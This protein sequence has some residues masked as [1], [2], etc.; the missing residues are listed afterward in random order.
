M[1]FFAVAA[2][3]PGRASRSACEA[4]LMSTLS[5]AP[6]ASAGDGEIARPQARTAA[7]TSVYRVVFRIFHLLARGPFRE[8]PREPSLRFPVILSHGR[9]GRRELPVRRRA[10]GCRPCTASRRGERSPCTAGTPLSRAWP[11]LASG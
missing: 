2:P 11:R 8:S 3:T 5:F 9:R 10:A 6:A 1:I 4:L 7:R